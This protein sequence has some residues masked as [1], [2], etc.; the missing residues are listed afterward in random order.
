[1]AC[2]W[3][4][5]ADLRAGLDIEGLAAEHPLRVRENVFAFSMGCASMQFNQ[6]LNL[7]LDPLGQANSGEQLYH[8]I[9]ARMEPSQFEQCQPECMFPGIVASGDQCPYIVTGKRP[10]ASD[11]APPVIILAPSRNFRQ[12]VGERLI[13]FAE[14]SSLQ[15]TMDR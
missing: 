11:A 13:G 5:S 8:F 2:H 9:G 4:P 14:H 7:A 1:M 15:V 6:M 12:R 10:D 3:R